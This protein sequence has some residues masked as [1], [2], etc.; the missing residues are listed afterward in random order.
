MGSKFED[1][2]DR[3]CENCGRSLKE[4][5]TQ[6]DVSQQTVHIYN[7]HAAHIVSLQE[8][9]HRI[10]YTMANPIPYAYFHLMNL[11]LMANV[12]LLAT[13]SGLFRSY[14]AV[15]LFALA[16]FVY[17]GLREISTCMSDPFGEDSIDFP[18]A[19]YMRS[20]FDRV[21]S[22]NLA[23]TNPDMRKRLYK[24]TSDVQD[25]KDSNLKRQAKTSF[26]GENDDPG[27]GTAVQLKWS[28]KSVF[29]SAKEDRN[30]LKW[31]KISLLK[32]D[33]KESDLLTHAKIDPWKQKWIHLQE[34]YARATENS[35]NLNEKIQE[36]KE[37]YNEVVDKVERIDNEYPELVRNGPA[38]EVPDGITMG[39]RTHGPGQAKK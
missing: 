22:I 10:G 32:S 31:F 18:I 13:F 2:P 14:F 12:F 6:R 20:C 27:K 5:G 9:C 26:F 19:D 30:L 11:I 7:R 28:K 36:L 3:F 39:S 24:G 34:T 17:M 37:Q 1:V 23:F 16:M 15:I 4:D 29:E 21:V 33:V 8:A 25:F 35:N 38:I